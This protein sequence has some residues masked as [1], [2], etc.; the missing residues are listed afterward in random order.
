VSEIEQVPEQGDPILDRAKQLRAAGASI[1]EVK[2]YLRSKGYDTGDEA[3][4]AA[5][6]RPAVRPESTGALARNRANPSGDFPSYPTIYNTVQTANNAITLGLGPKFD[7]MLSATGDVVRGRDSFGHSLTKHL[8]SDRAGMADLAAK[9]PVVSGAANLAGDVGLTLASG[10]LGI[11]DA[12]LPEGAQ[13][14]RPLVRA[15]RAAWS[16]AKAGAPVGAISALGN[17]P[18][19]G[20][21]DES[22]PQSLA[23]QAWTAAKGA[24]VGGTVGAGV[25]ASPFVMRGG[26]TVAK[27]A[28]A[29]DPAERIIQREESRK[30]ASA[31]NFG[32][33]IQ[34]GYGKVPPADVLKFLGEPDVAPIV[35]ALKGTRQFGGMESTNPRFLDEIY[36][37]MS[38]KSGMLAKRLGLAESGTGTALNVPR[39]QQGEIRSAKDQLLEGMDAEARLDK[40]PVTTAQSPNPSLRE[41]L[42]N[43]RDRQTAAAKRNPGNETVAQQQTRTALERHG[44]EHVVSPPLTGQPVVETAPFMGGYR[45]AVMEEAK[46]RA[47]EG[48]FDRGTLA[49]KMS[50][51]KQTPSPKQQRTISPPAMGRW[52]QAG[53]RSEPERQAALEAIYGNAN[54][55]I[56]R[57]PFTNG[58]RALSG[59]MSLRNAIEPVSDPMTS[60][61]ILRTLG[62]TNLTFSNP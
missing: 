34:E 53:Q 14:A 21:P 55:A 35:D 27:V 37:T 62:L 22:L 41:G 32:K 9:H 59:A 56:H 46:R 7:A 16:G 51:R 58:R 11:V 1:D 39:V 50:L 13:A 3:P 49:G 28:R 61:N 31:V 4:A 43:F 8:E 54:D 60:D 44:A 57:S 24:T 33:A 19:T 42:Q 18:G 2:G 23:N 40:P 20:R 6:S 47:E 26:S 10:P 45:N 38:D 48:A 30:A 15:G 5:P 29:G 52:A 17:A 36:K 12:L 25:A